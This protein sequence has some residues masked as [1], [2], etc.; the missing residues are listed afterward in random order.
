M[1]KALVLGILL[2]LALLALALGR[3]DVPNAVGGGFLTFPRSVTDQSGLVVFS[4]LVHVSNLGFGCIDCHTDLF[5]FSRDSFSM[6]DNFAGRACGACHS[7]ASPRAAPTTMVAAFGVSQCTSCHAGKAN[8]FATNGPGPVTFD[9]EPHLVSAG[10]SCG[11]CHL[12]LFPR[13]FMAGIDMAFPHDANPVAC[14]TCHNGTTTSP[15]NEVAF[16]ASECLVC[17]KTS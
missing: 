13:D 2:V 6:A 1:R 10:Y 14:A 12:A 7:D 17:H 15:N 9:H 5:P 11:T 4:H 16:S 3:Q 8:T